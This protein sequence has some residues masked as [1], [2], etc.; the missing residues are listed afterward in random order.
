MSNNRSSA[1]DKWTDKRDS[2]VVNI[3]QS[4]FRAAAFML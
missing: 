2:G 3:E 1:N 4:D